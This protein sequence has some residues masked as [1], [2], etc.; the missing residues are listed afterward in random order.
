MLQIARVPQVLAI[1]ND[2]QPFYPLS[3]KY[4][5]GETHEAIAMALS[6]DEII[7]EIAS[8]DAVASAG[9]DRGM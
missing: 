4:D 7:H 1:F 6:M 2:P 9:D 8:K 3:K 5:N